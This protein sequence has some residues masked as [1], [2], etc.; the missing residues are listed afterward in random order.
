M[1]YAQAMLLFEYLGKTYG[2]GTVMDGFINGR[3]LKEG[4]GKSYWELFG[5]CTSEIRGMY[6][7]LFVAES[8]GGV[9]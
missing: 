8:R 6:G 5:E 4:V 7:P 1:N 2:M 3:S 9:S